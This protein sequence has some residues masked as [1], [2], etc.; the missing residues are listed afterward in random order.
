[1]RSTKDA[2]SAKLPA[3]GIKPRPALLNATYANE[4]TA[5]KNMVARIIIN[6]RGINLTIIATTRVKFIN[7][8]KKF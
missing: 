6:Q 4:V 3:S 1:M 2:L 7:H 5:H 8:A